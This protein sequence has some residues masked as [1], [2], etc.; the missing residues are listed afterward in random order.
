M[1]I[2]DEEGS[3]LEILQKTGIMHG[4]NT[5]STLKSN[6][7]YLVL[8][9]IVVVAFL[10]FTSI[11]VNSPTQVSVV[12]RLGQINATQGAGLYFV[13]PLIDSVVQYDT[14]IQSVE[15]I[16][17]IGKENCHAL[18]AATKDLQTVTVEVQVSYR[19]SSSDIVSL[20]K[21]VQDQSTFSNIIVPSS[22]EEAMKAS[23]SKYTAEELIINRSE[24]RDDLL[25]TLNEKFKVFSLELV[26]LNITN[27][28]FSSAF[29]KAIDE[30]SVV[31]QQIQ[32]QKAALERAAIDAQIKVTQAEGDAKSIGIQNKALQQSPNYL[33]LKKIEKWDG[34]LPVYYGGTDKLIFDLSQ[35]SQ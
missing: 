12:V 11:R 28:Q 8:A 4:M 29:E 16:T 26:S 25:K 18:N 1:D 31:Q 27:F 9:I 14:T 20:Y 17:N 23:A 21:L 24:V 19:I 7:F 5:M 33:E 2:L 35:K 3:S 15:C 30:K 22:I 32:I 13:I 34:K 10:I 6:K